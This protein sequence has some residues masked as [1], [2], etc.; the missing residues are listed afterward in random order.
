MAQTMT[1]SSITDGQIDKAGETLRT[2][3]C[4]HLR[5][6]RDELDSS[7]VQKALGHSTLGLDLL[8]VVREHIEEP[9]L[10][11]ISEGEN[12]VIPATDG[13]ALISEEKDVFKV[14]IDPDFLRLDAN[15][16]SNP[17]PEAVPRV[18]EMERDTTFE[19]IF[20]SVCKDKDK[21]CWTQS[22]IIGFVQKYPNWLHPE[23]WATFFP[24]KSKRNFFV[25][26]VYWYDPA[27]LL[28]NVDRREYDG[29]WVA[30]RRSRVVLPQL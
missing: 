8:A 9:I 5:E 30:G 25:A 21:I 13:K 10:R 11:C 20:D 23:G 22:Q 6:H 27:G 17:T 15:E 28:V 4:K 1:P 14:W 16:P 29:V 26:Y 12:L 2:T 24:F 7:A 3:F 19:H 18:Y